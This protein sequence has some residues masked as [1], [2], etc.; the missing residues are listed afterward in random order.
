MDT[1]VEAVILAHAGEIGEDRVRFGWGG[2]Q[3]TDIAD[4]MAVLGLTAENIGRIAAEHARAMKLAGTPVTLEQAVE[5]ARNFL[6]FGPRE[7]PRRM[8]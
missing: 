5:W 8:S 7:W 2:G 4:A 6:V 3:E 1:S